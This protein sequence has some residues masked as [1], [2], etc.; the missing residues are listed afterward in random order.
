[1]FYQPCPALSQVDTETMLLNSETLLTNGQITDGQVVSSENGQVVSLS[2]TLLTD[3][4]ISKLLL[5]DGLVVSL[6][7]KCLQIMVVFLSQILL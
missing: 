6:S 7:K 4:Q 1:M 3:V 5:S 2:K